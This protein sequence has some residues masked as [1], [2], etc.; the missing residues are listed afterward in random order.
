[1]DTIS[2]SCVFQ[3]F[4]RQLP[5]LVGVEAIEAFGYGGDVAVRWIADILFERKETV[6]VLVSNFEELFGRAGRSRLGG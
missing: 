2:R 1:M 5:V 6:S 4:E 3:F